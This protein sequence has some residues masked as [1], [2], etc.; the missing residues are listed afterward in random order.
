MRNVIALLACTAAWAQEPAFE[1]LGQVTVTGGDHVRARDRALDDALRQ[2]VEQA[3]AT[4]L[5][6]AQLVARSSELRL[7]I[8]PKARSYISNYRILDEG[9]T[10]GVFQVHVSAT[11]STGR[12]SRELATAPPAAETKLRALICAPAPVEKVAKETLVAR[13]VQ[14]LPPPEPCTPAD[15]AKSAQA[16][17][18]QGAIVGGS[19]VA[20]EGNIRGTEQVAA[21]AKVTLK[22]LEPGGKLLAD[23]NAERV[24]YDRTAEAA[25]DGAAR[26]AAT[27][28]VRNLQPI[29]AQRWPGT[30][31]AVTGG[32]TV[33]VNGLQRY[34]DYGA[35][36][37]SLSAMPGVA[38]VEPRR[39]ARGEVDL[40]VRTA[41]MASQLSAALDRAPPPGMRI[42]STAEGEGALRVEVAAVVAPE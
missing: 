32:V 24:A 2:A 31:D 14:I 38:G 23:G 25:A 12:L 29:L 41:S 33:H 16:S 6:P 7:R 34:L 40:F 28:T 26:A 21:R 19:E 8:Y 17:G 27:E 30:G 39:F 1:A 11:V 37:R 3:V 18:A 20:P 13:G 35:L 42:R 10:S 9:E 15:A 22:V 36:M 5:E 4:V